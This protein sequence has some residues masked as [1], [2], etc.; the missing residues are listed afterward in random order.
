MRGSATEPDSMALRG[1]NP[2]HTV[3]KMIAS[4]SGTNSASY[5]QLMK[6]QRSGGRSG[7]DG[8]ACR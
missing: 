6:T 5:G 1:M 8:N 2:Q 7:R 3:V 4:K